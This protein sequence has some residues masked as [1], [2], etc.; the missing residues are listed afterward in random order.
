VPGHKDV[1]ILRP[2]EPTLEENQM[3]AGM[4]RVY[5]GLAQLPQPTPCRPRALGCQRDPESPTGCF[6]LFQRADCEIVTLAP[7]HC[8]PPPPPPPDCGTDLFCGNHCCPPG[9]P[10]ANSGCCPEGT[11]VCTDDLVSCCDNGSSC[12]SLPFLGD[13]CVRFPCDIWDPSGDCVHDRSRPELPA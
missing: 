9:H 10:C 11:H 1:A 3:K 13:V 6:S 12:S 2:V 8:R 7:C 5:A 4:P